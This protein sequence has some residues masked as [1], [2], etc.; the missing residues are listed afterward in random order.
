MKKLS[1][2]S[3]LRLFSQFFHNLNI[4]AVYKAPS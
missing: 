4:P 3:E 2:N 1:T